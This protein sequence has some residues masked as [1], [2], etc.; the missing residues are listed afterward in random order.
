MIKKGDFLIS[1]PDSLGDYYFNRSIIIL[2]EVNKEEIV[3]FIVNKEMEYTLS[4]L[5]DSVID[6]KIKIFSGGPVNQDNLYFIHMYPESI[7][8]GINFYNKL[9]WGG[10]FKESIEM[11]NEMKLKNPSIKFFSG[12]SGWTYDQLIEEI[13]NGSWIIRKNETNDMFRE[14]Y[15]KMWGENMKKLD[16]KFKIWSNAPE[17]PQNN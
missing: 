13:N 3:G 14:D 8:N 9:Y 10:E 6:K 11:I 12:Y 17:D 7:R 1:T 2:T 4:D 15:N 16:G 5:D